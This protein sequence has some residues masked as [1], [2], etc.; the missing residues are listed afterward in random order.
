[1]NILVLE[2]D[3]IAFNIIEY[4][5]VRGYNVYH[6][7]SLLDVAYYLEEYPGLEFF[8]KLMF[9]V[10]VPKEKFSV[11]NNEEI[12]YGKKYGFSGFEFVARNYQNIS[13]KEIALIT[14]Y[15]ITLFDKVKDTKDRE[16]LDKLTIIDKGSDDFIMDLLSFLNG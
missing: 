8:D 1:M 5:T 13:H 2:D 15:K 16:V 6:A 4:L 7:Q 14:A 9:D 10:A 3:P 11:F 12:E